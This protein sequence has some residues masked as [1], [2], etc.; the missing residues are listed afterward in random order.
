MDVPRVLLR[1]DERACLGM[2]RDSPLLK[3]RREP[4]TRGEP[5]SKFVTDTE[6]TNET[7]T[8]PRSLESKRF[9]GRSVGVKKPAEIDLSVGLA[10]IRPAPCD[11]HSPRPKNLGRCVRLIC[12]G[13]GHGRI[14]TNNHRDSGNWRRV[15]A[16]FKSRRPARFSGTYHFRLEASLAC[17][18][19]S[20]LAASDATLGRL[21]IGARATPGHA[22]EWLERGCRSQLRQCPPTDTDCSNE[23]AD[24]LEGVGE[25]GSGV[26]R[27]LILV[28]VRATRRATYQMSP[29]ASERRGRRFQ[30]G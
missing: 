19:A 17:A 4:A 24:A 2:N 5:R 30:A 23:L 3:P 26:K 12:A 6:S 25:D 28:N 18:R 11:S 29:S 21:F 27:S 7:G 13:C 16:R 9:C 15:Y 14:A 20:S 1:S 10:D 22:L 8:A